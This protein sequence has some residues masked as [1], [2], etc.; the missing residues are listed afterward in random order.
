MNVKKIIF[1]L[2]VLIQQPVIATLQN[3]FITFIPGFNDPA[4]IAITPNGLY[5]YVADDGSNSVLVINTNPASPAF[6]TLIAA[7]NLTGVFSS[8]LDIAITPDNNFAYVADS[9]NGSVQLI[10]INPSSPTYNS[11]IATPGLNG[12]FSSPSSLAIT[13]DGNYVYVVDAGS[14]SVSVI[15]SN[16]LSPT[17]N[18]VLTT[19][20]LNGILNNAFEIVL[21]P[22]GK[23]A[24]ISN[25]SGSVTVIDT[26]P[27]SPTFNT[28]I[29]APGLAAVNTEPEGLAITAN[30]LYAYVS[31]GSGTNVTVLDVNPASPTFNT[32]VSAPKLLAAFNNPNGVATTADGN[33][34]YVSNFSGTSGAISS[35]SVINTNPQSLAFN[36]TLSTPGL[37]LPSTTRFVALTV[38]PNARFVYVLDALNDT[39]DVIYTGIVGTPGNFTGCKVVNKFLM[40]LDRANKL[41]W[42]APTIGNPPVT[43][44]L[45]RDAALTQLVATVPATSTLQYVDHNRP[46][47]VNDTYYI[48]AVDNNGN[49]SI[50]AS[51]TVTQYCA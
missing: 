45:Y 37:A 8:P 31:D 11:I 16:P 39:V 20:A 47:N 41:T 35:V 5:G 9:G 28:P 18:T 43:Y 4:D 30:G 46:A 24:Y 1:L 19:P 36:S 42:S 26:N 13:P 48:V 33:Y 7:P 29:A 2:L 38:T 25:L 34:A 22:S 23:Y 49:I 27:L 32:I 14:N 17:Y 10:D 40:Q 3:V 21:T 6:N 50:P 51:I 12:V 15:D 44:Q